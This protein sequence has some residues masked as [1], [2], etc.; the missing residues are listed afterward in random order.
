[1]NNFNESQNGELV[2]LGAIPT[3]PAGIFSQTHKDLNEIEKGAKIAVPNDAP[4]QLVLML[5][6]K[7][8]DG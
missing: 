2:A 7:K 8:Q 3:V 1:M 5:Y 4:I 6:Y